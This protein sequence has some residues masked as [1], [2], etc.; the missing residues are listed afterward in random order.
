MAR[1]LPCV[2]LSG[3]SGMFHNLGT[4]TSV[5][6]VTTR[7]MMGEMNVDRNGVLRR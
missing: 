1:E 5:V 3:E 2:T 7:P 4:F 6:F